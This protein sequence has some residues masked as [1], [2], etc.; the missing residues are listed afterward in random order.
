MNVEKQE[1]FLPT[2]TEI[3]KTKSFIFSI[4]PEAKFSGALDLSRGKDEK[5]AV[6][7][8]IVGKEELIKAN[9]ASTT[10]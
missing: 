8:I 6:K 9:P 3:L 10:K 5:L 4:F 1:T 2:H 7:L